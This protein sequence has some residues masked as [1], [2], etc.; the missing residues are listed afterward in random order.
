[1]YTE[2]FHLKML[3]FENVPDPVFFFD[4]GD[5]ARVRARVENSLRVGRGLAI[6][7]GPIGSGKTTLSQIIKSDFENGIHL[8]WIAE[9]PRNSMELF[10]FIAQELGLSPSNRRED[11]HPAGHPCGTCSN[12]CER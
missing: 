6:V 3:P 5:H 8:I 10:R 11:I 7:T 1:M 9:P 12:P 4:A 2:H